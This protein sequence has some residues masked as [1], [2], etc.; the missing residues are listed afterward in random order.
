M[1]THI[2]M[3]EFALRLNPA[4]FPWHSDARDPDVLFHAPGSWTD[5]HGPEGGDFTAA[6]INCQDNLRI[7]IG[8]AAGDIYSKSPESS[9]WSRSKAPFGY[10]TAISQLTG[11]N[12]AVPRVLALNETG[13]IIGTGDGGETWRQC[14]AGLE[15]LRPLCLISQPLHAALLYAGTDRGLMASPDGGLSWI[16]L[17]F[18]DEVREVTAIATDTENPLRFFLADHREGSARVLETSDGGRNF[19]TILE[20]PEYGAVIHTLIFNNADNSLICGG[21]GVDGGIFWIPLAESDHWVEITAGLPG[22]GI[23]CLAGDSL[24]N[25]WAGSDGAGIYQFQSNGMAWR[26]A[27]TEPDRRHVQALHLENTLLIGTFS[28]GGIAIFDGDNWKF[29]NAGLTGRSVHAVTENLSGTQCLADSR[30]FHRDFKGNWDTVSG[31]HQAVDLLET[32]SDLLAVSSIRGTYILGENGE[33][34]TASPCQGE[35]IMARIDLS[36]KFICVLSATLQGRSCFLSEEPSLNKCESWRQISQPIPQNLTV[37]DMAVGSL[38]NSPWITLST[39]HGLIYLNTER[40]EWFEPSEP[41]KTLPGPLHPVR[42]ETGTLLVG[43]GNKLMLSRD[44]GMTL[45]PECLKQFPSRITSISTSD[46]LFKVIWVGTESGGLYATYLP[47]TWVTLVSDEPGI[48][49]NDM[50]FSQEGH[51]TCATG[52]VSCVQV[53]V[54]SLSIRC[55]QQKDVDGA[56]NITL[57]LNNPCN[58]LEADF[59]L[60]AVSDKPGPDYMRMETG[61][62]TISREPA[63]FPVILHQGTS[64]TEICLGTINFRDI[65]TGFF[66]VAG[67]FSKNSWNPVAPV[68]GIRVDEGKG[69]KRNR[70]MEG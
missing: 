39:S 67:L 57:T 24:N 2:L 62:I 25:L 54:P 48:A 69:E 3:E 35:V 38:K 50:A 31:I 5:L 13:Q 63:P 52:G 40:N 43:V 65:G 16:P 4:I 68:Q 56:L 61:K 9:V 27:D 47:N 7:W 60:M 37:F 44:C 70:G 53:R 32:G 64:Q 41:P 45:D 20:R 8:S 18:S 42:S 6:F 23:R 14:N 19:H 22:A 15:D 30:V 59:H 11:V 58:D 1:E 33:W 49:I 36:G 55:E 12:G 34:N 21:A 26:R 66:L 10:R 28:G 17:F 46:T 51:V 29:A